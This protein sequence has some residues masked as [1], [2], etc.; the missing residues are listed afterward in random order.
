MTP[1]VPESAGPADA[2]FSASAASVARVATRL[3]FP[4]AVR[5]QSID[6]QGRRLRL[7][8]GIQRLPT[9]VLSLEPSEPSSTAYLRRGDSQVSY[10]LGER[11]RVSPAAIEP[12]LKS[13]CALVLRTSWSQVRALV[14]PEPPAPVA[15][16]PEVPP[17]P[18]TGTQP[19]EPEPVAPG[20]RADME[21]GCFL[22]DDRHSRDLYASLRF[23]VTVTRVVHAD[24]E[25]MNESPMARLVQQP[26]VVNPWETDR[27][28]GTPEG[29]SAAP[30]VQGLT[31]DIGDLEI[32][33]GTVPSLEALLAHVARTVTTDVV[34]VSN[35]CVPNILGEDLDAAVERFRCACPRPVVYTDQKDESI[36]RHLA[37]LVAQLADQAGDDEAPVPGSVAL[38]GLHDARGRAE[39]AAL[40][41]AAGVAVVGDLI[42]EVSIQR[43][44]QARR[45]EV[46]VQPLHGAWGSTCES[47]IERLAGR[48]LAL[49]APFGVAGS[50]AWLGSVAAAVHREEAFER[51]WEALWSELRPA[52]EALVA[53]TAGRRLGLLLPK[54]PAERLLVDGVLAG[55]PVLAML[56]EAGFGVELGV[57]GEAELPASLE[58]AGRRHPHA[59]GALHVFPIASE[60]ELRTVLAGGTLVAALSEFFE[61]LRLTS[62]GVGRFSLADLEAGPVGAL[63]TATRLLNRGAVPFLG[64]YRT[65]LERSPDHG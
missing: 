56:L 33:A 43:L 14:E 63:R 31:T 6:V 5:L 38:L 7:V 35:S 2:S 10:R 21:W 24:A 37:S 28:S 18:P 36:D 40:L 22:A 48:P 3:G 29:P 61:D 64:R 23:D 49:S 4:A 46:L 12:V 25:C 54:A 11:P 26:F 58:A 16:H 45:A 8:L 65:A 27:A 32:I 19:T 50:R 59:E 9:V 1:P 39:L 20:P 41:A 42:P 34:V 47:L 15:A 62:A 52:W 30:P 13:L 17:S 60:A 53:A 44:R 55:L 57:I 51:Q